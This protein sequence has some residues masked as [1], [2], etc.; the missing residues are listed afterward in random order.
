METTITIKNVISF[1][2]C[3]PFV[4]S[5]RTDNIFSDPMLSNNEEL[6]NN[7]INAIEK[8]DTHVVFS[9]CVNQQMIGLFSF[10][11]L[12][13][14]KYLEMLVG[15]SRYEDAYSAMFAYLKE[16]YIGYSADFV[17][18]PNNYL[19]YNCLK[20]NGAEFYEEEQRMVYNNSTLNIDT[21]GIELLTEPYISSYI[22]IHQTDMYWTADKILAAKDRFRTFIAIEKGI[23]VGYLD[24][25]YCYKENEPYDLWVKEEYRKRGY[26]RKL[27]A[28][29]LEMNKPKGMMLLIEIHNKAAIHLYE[30]MGFEKIDNQNSI[31][32]HLQM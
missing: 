20:Q 27:L 4:N 32:A 17:F 10:L 5:F 13:D 18:N 29:A 24:V 25:T 28:K 26:G 1:N 9:I 11:A 7:L 16:H 22:D 15:L 23:V 6:E 19:L 21:T 14:E 8:K 30:S 2:D 31:A 3:E 12:K